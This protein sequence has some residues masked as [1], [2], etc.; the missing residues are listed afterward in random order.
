MND[1]PP[2][3]LKGIRQR[4]ELSDGDFSGSTFTNINLSG[5]VFNDVNLSG[6]VFKDV[7]LSGAAIADCRIDGMTIEGI[8]VADLMAAYRAAILKAG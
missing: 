8:A 7:N 3:S 6:A 1:S 4:L 2:M 5:A